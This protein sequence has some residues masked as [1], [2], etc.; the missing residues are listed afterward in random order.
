MSTEPKIVI[1][2]ILQ[3]ARTTVDGGWRISFDLPAHESNNVV[4]LSKLNNTVLHVVIIPAE[5][6][7]KQKE[8]GFD[9]GDLKLVDDFRI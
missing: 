4:E 9:I 1:N 3:G 8:D 2:A 7:K 6:K 5:T